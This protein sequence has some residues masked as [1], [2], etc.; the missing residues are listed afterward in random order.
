[1]VGHA[2]QPERIRR[3]G[4]LINL[5]A[6]DPES[7]VRVVAFLQGLQQSGWL[8]GRNVRIDYRWAAGD[9]ERIRRYAADLLTSDVILASGTEVVASLQ[10]A[11]RTV[12]IVFVQVTDPVGNGLVAS[13]ARP[14]GNT[15]GF[16][17][18]EYGISGKWLDLLKQIAPA[19]TRVAILRDSADPAG[20][21]QWGALQSAAPAMGVELRPVGV[22]DAVEID[23]AVTDFARLPNGGLIVTGG[24]P[25]AVHRELIVTL[26]AR[27]RL[28]A[29]YPF[30]YHVTSGG[31]ISYGPDTLDQYR[32]AAVYVDRILKGEQPADLPGQ[33]PTKYELVVN[34]KTARALGLEGPPTLLA[35]STR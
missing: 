28:P 23:R 32:R 7:P 14:G 15:T 19:V 4:A 22:R 16:I 17:T 5:R 26:A 3:I 10:Q 29:I 34:L 2:Q 18:L 20:I 30:R 1:M 31:L 11:T 12:P 33:A 9:R 25:T 27:Y 8:D 35:A 13:L 6:D 24:A 21:G